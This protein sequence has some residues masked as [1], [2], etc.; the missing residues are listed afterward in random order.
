MKE[1]LA[2]GNSDEARPGRVLAGLTAFLV[3]AAAMGWWAVTTWAD[4]PG[5]PVQAAEV[6]SGDDEKVAPVA[7]AGERLRLHLSTP[8]HLVP[9]HRAPVRVS[10][11]DRDSRVLAPDT[12]VVVYA[13]VR[14]VDDE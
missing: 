9:G 3:A 5:S 11:T 10:L 8:R 1:R 4:G 14:G 2:V 6:E 7:Q 13:V 12:R